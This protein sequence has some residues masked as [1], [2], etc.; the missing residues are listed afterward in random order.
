VKTKDYCDKSGNT[1]V[2]DIDNRV[3]GVKGVNRT[4]SIKII[5]I[6]DKRIKDKKRDKSKK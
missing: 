1:I 5:Y 3:V 6:V 2:E 4:V